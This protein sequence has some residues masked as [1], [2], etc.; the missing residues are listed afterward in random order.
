MSEILEGAETQIS[1]EPPAERGPEG[2]PDL[3]SGLDEGNLPYPY[4][5]TV[6]EE[7]SSSFSEGLTYFD[8]CSYL[9]HMLK[10]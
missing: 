9:L 3:A 5:P 4:L 1:Q 6:L 7:P 10:F 2:P 8:L